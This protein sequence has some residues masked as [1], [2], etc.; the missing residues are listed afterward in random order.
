MCFTSP[1]VIQFAEQRFGLYQHRST[2]CYS[3]VTNQGS[4]T[5]MSAVLE[6]DSQIALKQHANKNRPTVLMLHESCALV[7]R[8]AAFE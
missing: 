8:V 1:P 4:L 3:G 7:W 6:R 2:T 5:L